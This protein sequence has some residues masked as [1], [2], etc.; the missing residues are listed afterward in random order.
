M[1]RHTNPVAFHP[2]RG[3]YGTTYQTQDGTTYVR[4]PWG[5]RVL[6]NAV[7]PCIHEAQ[8]IFARATSMRRLI[9]AVAFVV[10]LGVGILVTFVPALL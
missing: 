6:D 9:H 4:T 5:T 8:R 7:G 1:K 3:L 10:G 2:A